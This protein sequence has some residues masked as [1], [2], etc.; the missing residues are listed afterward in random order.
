MLTINL[1]SNQELLS[2]SDVHE[3]DEHFFELLSKYPPSPDLLYLI[4]GD[5]KDKGGGEECFLKIAEKTKELVS[6]GLAF[7]VKGNHELKAIKKNRK[8]QNPHPIYAWLDKQPIA[9]SFLYPNQS[10]YTCVHAGITPHMTWDSIDHDINVCYTRV[11]DKHGNHVHMIKNKDTN[12]WEP[13]I[14]EVSEW[15]N[16][17]DGRFGYVISGHNCHPDNPT[18]YNHSCNID[19]GVFNTGTLSAVKFNQFGKKEVIKINKPRYNNL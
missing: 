10:R 7:F 8:N 12:H 2:V 15:H 5:L 9:L 17:Y 18:F 11:L 4:L 3:H 16:V 14:K 1:K 6:L 19:S 13:A